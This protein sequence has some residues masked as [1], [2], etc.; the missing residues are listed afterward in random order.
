MDLDKVV[1]NL[2]TGLSALDKKEE[3]HILWF[4]ELGIEDV[5]LVGG[6]NAS[7]GEMY[8]SLTKLGVKVPYGFAISAVAYRYFIEESQLKDKIKESLAGLDTSNLH[9]LQQRGQKVRTLILNAEFPEMLRLQILKA[10]KAMVKRYGAQV[11]V[12]V[13]S[14]AT[15]EDLPDASFAGQQETYL[16]VHSEEELL[17]SCKKCFASLFTDRAISYREDKK[18]DH[19]N[20]ALSIGVQKMVRS[21][22]ASSGV[23]FSIDTESGFDNVVFVTGAYG[24]GENVVQGAVNPDEFL[25]FKPTL[26][27]GF[28]PIISRTI[29]EKHMK[30]VYDHNGSK[31][32]KN[33][34]VPPHEREK[35]SLKD[36]E[37]LTLA[38][39]A[40]I[41]EDHYSAKRGHYQPMDM[42]WAKDG[43]DGQLYI[44]Q[45][46]PETVQS[47]K[48]RS[49]IQTYSMEEK[50]SILTQGVSVG[51]KIGHGVAKI[52]HD[53]HQAN[54]FKEGDVL[55]TDMTDPDW[56]PIMKKASAII[57]NRG[58]RTCHAAIIS[59]EM[60]VPAVVGC[61]DATKCIHDSQKITVSCAEGE[62]GYVYD[63]I[64]K[65]KVSEISVKDIPETKT[66]IMMNLGNPHLA[67]AQ[68]F[69]PNDGVGL[70]REEFI[71]NSG[72]QIHPNA[73]LHFDELKKNPEAA[74]E[75][76]KIEMLTK[77]YEDKVQYYIDKLAEGMS[78]IAAAFY[79]K[80]V[81]MRLSDFKSNEYAN[82]IGG[83]FFEPKEDNPM[84]GFRGASRY[85]SENFKEAFKL[86]CLAVRNAREVFGLKNL[87]LMIPF[88]RT[89]DEAKRV[90]AVMKE[91]GIE[92]GK[93]GLEIYLMCEIPS[94]VVLADQFL[95]HVDGYSLGTNDLTQLTLGVDRDSELVSHVYDERNQAVKDLVAGVINKCNELGKY[96][97]ICGQAPSDYP[98][99]ARFVVEAGI[100]TMSLNPDTIVK[101][102]L[103][104]AE[105]EKHLGTGARKHIEGFNVPRSHLTSVAGDDMLKAPHHH[106][107]HKMVVKKTVKKA[108][109][110][111]KA[112]KK[113]AAKKVVKKVVKKAAAPKKAVK[114]AAPKKK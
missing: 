110:P 19:F 26:E 36:E 66:K 33:I 15:A 35:Y 38:R 14:S 24:L 60:G 97:G 37:V 83:R 4:D 29:G 109:A 79:P 84:I 88:C 40:I 105:L 52:I 55:V 96:I 47:R 61:G 114:K 104:I 42:E 8:S 3:K 87:K 106:N 31:L 75:V 18:Y 20:I 101:T 78:M 27:Q 1:K 73:L 32:T 5:P 86:E 45:A 17:H 2:E 64:L 72:V 49:T 74:E 22:L 28:S 80:K 102:K 9:N 59:R 12:A 34:P 70:A 65:Y 50:G 92:R 111:K 43:K 108:A 56:E 44:V 82:L 21:D 7:L 103:M 98:E 95:Q 30:M 13:R 11:D 85:Y 41:I 90:L 100:Q 25:V 23:M 57:T 16:N 51:D 76:K 63:G 54:N 81:I 69:L 112:V 99:F 10:Y 93:D 91:A 107:Q 113:V 53:I 94:N 6:K 46:R 71:I 67:F 62:K 48:D 58:G 77:G 68:S 39:W 89:V